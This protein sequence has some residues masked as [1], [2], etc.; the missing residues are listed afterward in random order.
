MGRK[1]A[2][3]RRDVPVAILIHPARAAGT[4][5]YGTTT[6]KAQRTGKPERRKAPRCEAFPVS[7]GPAAQRIC[8]LPDTMTWT[9]DLPASTGTGA[10]LKASA[11]ACIAIMRGAR[12]PGIDSLL[13]TVTSRS[14]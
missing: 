3:H 12:G 2:R 4:T 11:L 7:A 6:G 14:V 1:A 8:T 10:S 5:G 9:W 13:F